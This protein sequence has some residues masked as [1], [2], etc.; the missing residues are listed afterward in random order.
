MGKYQPV[1]TIYGHYWQL[2]IVENNVARPLRYDEIK[3][4]ADRLNAAVPA[5]ARVGE[6][7][8]EDPDHGE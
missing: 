6:L 5:P 4:V 2:G 8:T 1:K 7:L 3:V